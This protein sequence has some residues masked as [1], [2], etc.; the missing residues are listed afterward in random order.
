MVH[1]Y[2]ITGAGR[3]F[4]IYGSKGDIEIELF[5]SEFSD[6]CKAKFETKFLGSFRYNKVTTKLSNDVL[7]NLV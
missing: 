5:L 2:D 6:M 7:F 4:M 1:F 3:S